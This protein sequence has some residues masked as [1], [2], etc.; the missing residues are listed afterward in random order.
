M[1]EN[2]S[3]EVAEYLGS[4]YTADVFLDPLCGF[5]H[6]ADQGCPGSPGS[7][8]RFCGDCCTDI[9]ERYGPADCATCGGRGCLPPPHAKAVGVAARR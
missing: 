2:L 4:N 6:S 9:G 8:V 3:G 5:E 1:T 7:Q